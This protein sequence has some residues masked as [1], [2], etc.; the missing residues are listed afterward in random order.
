LS[1]VSRLSRLSAADWRWLAEALG[2][3]VLVRLALWCLPFRTTWA[4]YRRLA[5]PWRR[6]LRPVS[7][8]ILD[9][10]VRRAARMVP[11]ATCLTR[12]L[13]LSILM[14]RSGHPYAVRLGVAREGDCILAHA[15]VERDAAPARDG[16]EAGRYSAFPALGDLPR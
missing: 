13:A 14:Q 7:P 5:R 16:A 2:W 6:P 8:E 1:I 4:A 15:W 12:S 3:V 9:V 10:A 11:A